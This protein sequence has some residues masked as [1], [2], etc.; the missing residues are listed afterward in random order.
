MQLLGIELVPQQMISLSNKRNIA[1]F[2]VKVW[3]RLP[4]NFE[5]GPTFFIILFLFLKDIA[6]TRGVTQLPEDYYTICMDKSNITER[7]LHE[8]SCFKKVIKQ[9]GEKR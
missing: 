5:H 4:E 6:N 1:F 2:G 3:H 8:Y 9:V 7:I